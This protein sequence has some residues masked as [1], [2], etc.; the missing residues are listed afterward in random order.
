MGLHH[1]AKTEIVAAP[2]RGLAP[3]FRGVMVEKCPLPTVMFVVLARNQGAKRRRAA[4]D[5][6]PPGERSPVL[7]FT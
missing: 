6:P 4:P 7:S 1:K 3:P 5:L 2:T